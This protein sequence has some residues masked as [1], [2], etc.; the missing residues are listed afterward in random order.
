MNGRCLSSEV[1][2]ALRQI[3]REARLT[4]VLEVRF[5]EIAQGLLY[6]EIARIHDVS[7]NTIKTE[8]RHL[9]RSIGVN[10][11][12]EIERAAEAAQLRSED[13]ATP[14]EICGFLRLRFE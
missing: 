5:I 3:A 1:V 10:C 6:R 13:G 7:M 2:G 8:T 4:P 9:Y 14:E 12:H 11:R